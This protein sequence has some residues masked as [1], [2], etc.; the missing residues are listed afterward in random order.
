MPTEIKRC[1]Y[2]ESNKIEHEFQDNKYGKYIRVFNLKESGKGSSCTVCNGGLKS[3]KL[4]KITPT[5][6]MQVGVI[7]F[8][9]LI[10]YLQKDG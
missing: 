1:G 5:C 2:C 4:K 3:K 6:Y 10:I 8:T 9:P 7:F